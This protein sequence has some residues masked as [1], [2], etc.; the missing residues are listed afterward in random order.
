MMEGL[1]QILDE[2]HRRGCADLVMATI[3]EFNKRDAEKGWR[4][5]AKKASIRP[6]G[7]GP[8]STDE[9][10]GYGTATRTRS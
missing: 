8:R 7:T 2:A 10:A 5:D 6:A 3:A 4:D 9:A 1:A